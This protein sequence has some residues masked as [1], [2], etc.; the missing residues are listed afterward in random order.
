LGLAN[1]TPSPPGRSLRQRNELTQELPRRGGIQA[2]VD[3]DGPADG[4]AGD[5]GLRHDIGRPQEIRV[6]G[7]AAWSNGPV[8]EKAVCIPGF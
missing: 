7:R 1:L 6:G 4:I 5:G 3:V 8:L 2:V